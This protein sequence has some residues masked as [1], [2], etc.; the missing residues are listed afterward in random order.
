LFVAGCLIVATGCPKKDSSNPDGRPKPPPANIEGA[1]KPEIKTTAE[2]LAKEAIADPKAA[3]TKYKDKVVELEGK[4]DFANKII[5][6]GKAFHLAGAKKNP[7]DVVSVGIICFPT[8]AEQEKIW[9]LGKGQKVKVIGHVTGINTLGVYL[10]RCTVQELEKSPTVQISAE[11]LTAEFAKDEAAGKKKYLT[12]E[13][14]PKEI[15]IDGTVT[16]LEQSKDGLYT[17]KLAGK[18]GLTVNCTINK[19]TYESLKKGDKV[20]IKGDLSGFYKNEKHVNVNTAFVL[21]KG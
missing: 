17:A 12:E 18:D 8:D 10:D 13:G 21:K 16:D 14:D 11:D 19:E 4:I 15:I 2:G 5:G 9:W 1:Q 7:K 6:N 20:T 3:E